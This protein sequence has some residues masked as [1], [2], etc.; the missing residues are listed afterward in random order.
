MY[1][2]KNEQRTAWLL[3]LIFAISFT[4][5]VP[6]YLFY[7]SAR[8]RY[9]IPP[10]PVWIA[11]ASVSITYIGQYIANRFKQFW[12]SIGI[13]GLLSILWLNPVVIKRLNIVDNFSRN[14]TLVGLSKWSETSLPTG[15]IALDNSNWMVFDPLWGGYTHS[16]RTWVNRADWLDRPMSEWVENYVFYVQ[17]SGPYPGD[18]PEFLFGQDELVHLKSFP[19]PSENNK[20]S[21]PALHI[22]HLLPI[23]TELGI[24]FNEKINLRGYDLSTNSLAS[25]ESLTWTP[26]W[27]INQK[28]EHVYQVFLHFVPMDNFDV[29]AQAD[30][31]PALATRP[32]N[33]WD[34][35]DETIIGNTFTI[36]L[37]ETLEAGEYRLIT[38]L[39]DLDTLAR[40][41]TNEALDYVVIDTITVNP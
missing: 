7:I 37:P 27:S 40:L 34:D 30:G 39:Y 19:I 32:T 15:T 23:E 12:L 16:T 1:Q 17:Y 13:I 20:W 35:P 11:L 14:N 29:V 24:S 28:P 41:T 21:G 2:Q 5:L 26:Y 4:W 33:T 38:G 22:Y 31:T 8:D 18:N 25:G 10:S 9:V 36:S 6:G 3:L